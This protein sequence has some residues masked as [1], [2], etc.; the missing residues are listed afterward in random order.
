MLV[1]HLYIVAGCNGVG[2]ATASN[3]ILP[4][5]LF[6]ELSRSTYC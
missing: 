4:K 5:S 6:V 3:T 2:K 1:K